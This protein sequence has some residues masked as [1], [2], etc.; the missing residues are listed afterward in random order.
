MGVTKTMLQRY[1]HVEGSETTQGYDPTW[2]LQD[3]AVT[4]GVALYDHQG[5]LS[6]TA[7][8][9]AAL[10]ELHP[11]RPP[12]PSLPSG[13][14]QPCS[15]TPLFG[16]SGCWN[17]SLFLEEDATGPCTGSRIS[18]LCICVVIYSLQGPHVGFGD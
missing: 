15:P 1:F 18:R 8:G 5:H 3:D 14:H 11:G 2:P 13:I 6:E 4:L 9:R 10:E 17:V 16:P 12:P 7:R